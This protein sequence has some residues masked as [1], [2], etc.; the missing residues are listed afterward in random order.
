MSGDFKKSG[1]GWQK[2]KKV[3][4]NCAPAVWLHLGVHRHQRVGVGRLAGAGVGLDAGTL[5]GERHQNCSP[6]ER[7]LMMS[8][9]VCAVHGVTVALKLL[10]FCFVI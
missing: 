3:W 6:L 2:E 8:V 7:L 4:G 9:L 1:A 5:V 10:A